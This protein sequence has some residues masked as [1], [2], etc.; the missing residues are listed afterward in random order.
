M[1][2]TL[3]YLVAN[4]NNPGTIVKDC[5]PSECKELVDNLLSP[6][7]ASDENEEVIGEIESETRRRIWGDDE[8]PE[9]LKAYIIG[10]ELS[11]RISS[12][13]L[14]DSS[15]LK[16]VWCRS[17]VLR[18]VDGVGH[19]PVAV[20]G[21]VDTHRRAVLARGVDARAVVGGGDVVLVA[22]VLIHNSLRFFVFH[23]IRA[24]KR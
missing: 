24:S 17:G 12:L 15:S 13:P 7:P 21:G 19:A 20:I 8:H 9:T 10:E 16:R 18:R 22:T 14:D 4:V 11:E 5:L 1:R 2:N 3:Q 23:F 6:L